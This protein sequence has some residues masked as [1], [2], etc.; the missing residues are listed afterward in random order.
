MLGAV[1]TSRYAR[2]V[3]L[4]RVLVLVALT[5]AVV[6]VAPSRFGPEPPVEIAVAPA[7]PAPAP[8]PSRVEAAFRRHDRLESLLARL[9]LARA[10]VAGVTAALRRAVDLRR[11]GLGERLI[12][13]RAPDGAPVGVTL[14][15]SVLEQH[16]A[17]P[18]AEGWAV[19]TTTVP[20]ETRVER[21]EGKLHDSLFSSME[22]LGERA[23]LTSLFVSLFEWDFDF[24]ADALPEDAFR[25]LVEK[26]YAAGQFVGYGA[27]L[28]AEYESRG[29]PRLTA[30]RFGEPAAYFDGQGRA[31]RKTFLRA[32]LDFTRI[33]SG[34]SHARQHPVL[35]G[36]RPHLA[37]DYGAPVG[38]PVRAVADGVVES[39]GWN[40]GYG[41]SVTLRHGRGYSTMYN[42]L[43]SALVRRGQRVQQ[44]EVV[45]RVGST[46]LSTGPHLDY[47]VMRQGRFVNPLDEKF[48]PGAPVARERL[49]A[50]RAHRDQLL[51]QLR[52]SAS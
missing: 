50:F 9:G 37:V 41:I 10:D 25:L 40:G 18:G 2:L 19:E 42:H 4:A 15:R 30:V 27:I 6:V 1:R 43:S 39:A 12:V 32:P 11:L 17:R 36:L 26:R 51:Q 52:P 31:V 38:T 29:R 14:W 45:G 3:R 22:R 13:E 49:D 20:V 46:G 21:V 24:A 28:A 44:R 35:G 8:E 47:R 34:F 16:V 48:L 5:A 7:P 33:T 23:V